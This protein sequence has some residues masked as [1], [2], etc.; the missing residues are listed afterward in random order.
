MRS[1]GIPKQLECHGF[2]CQTPEDA[3]V[4]AAT[5][6]QSLMS[7]MGSN[8][9]QKTRRPKNRNG[10]G[11]VS[12]ASSQAT[13]NLV[14]SVKQS[15]RRSNSQRSSIPPPSRQTRK[16]RCATSS[17][18]G[19]SDTLRNVIEESSTEERNKKKSSKSKRAP[20]IPTNPPPL[21]SKYIGAIV[22]HFQSLIP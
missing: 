3:I 8:Q 16:K 13:T 18:S 9:N 10:I 14:Q 12:I 4:I 17:L 19:E 2:V 22:Y 6:Y 15:V 1:G 21:M 11:C 5:L 7:H 20:P